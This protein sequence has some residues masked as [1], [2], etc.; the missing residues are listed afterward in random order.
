[1][2]GTLF[3]PVIAIMLV[4]YYILKRKQYDP[5][6][7]VTGSGKHYWYRN[8]IN[9]KAYAAYIVGAIFAYYFSYVVIL[10][11]G[12]TVAT[13]LLTSAVYWGLMKIGKNVS[14]PEQTSSEA[15]SL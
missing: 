12:A 3:I 1:M 10:P 8:G 13:F 6:E 9:F 2:I 14:V 7:I 5:D 11:T 4:D 15:H